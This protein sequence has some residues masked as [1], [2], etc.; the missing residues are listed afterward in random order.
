MTDFT[1]DPG[2]LGDPL[3]RNFEAAL[4]SLG[5]PDA[6]PTPGILHHLSSAS[7]AEV[8]LWQA[9]WPEITPERRREVLRQMTEA[10]EAD[11]QLDFRP[12]MTALI[13]DADPEVRIAAIDGLWEASDLGLIDRFANRLRADADDRVR[14]RAAAALGAYV[15]RGEMEDRYTARVEPALELLI[16]VAADESEAVEVRRRALESAGYAD[17]DDVHALIEDAI[18]AAELGLQA[19]ALR[20]MGHSADAGWGPDVVVWLDHV[21]P[22]LRFE[23]ARAAGELMLDAAVPRLAEMIEN[24]TDRAVQVEAIMALGEIGGRKAQHALERMS[25]RLETEPEDDEEDLVAAVDD[26]ISTAALSEGSMVLG[27]LDVGGG[28]SRRVRDGAVGGGE[29]DTDPD[30]DPG[31]DLDD[32]LDDDEDWSEDGEDADWAQI[33]AEWDAIEDALD[34]ELEGDLDGDIDV[35]L[36]GHI[37]GNARP[38]P[39]R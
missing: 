23:A 27:G 7:R 3:I 24:E 35:D 13:D 33:Q 36:N 22:E 29:L 21:D 5:D 38:G 28:V 20:A 15:E 39:D 14:A 6:K 26:A 31:V 18:D 16:Q 1:I 19:G 32:E 11:F 25:E 4:R 37:Q 9:I 8:A 34:Q 2:V 10:S 30:V 17:R 12:I